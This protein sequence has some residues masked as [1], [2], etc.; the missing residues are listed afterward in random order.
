MALQCDMCSA[1]NFI[2]RDLS[3]QQMK[4]KSH[5]FIIHTKLSGAVFH[6]NKTQCDKVDNAIQTNILK[7]QF[8]NV[9]RQ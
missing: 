3:L 9:R 5:S 7:F 6:A 1:V 2:L 8:L 4:I